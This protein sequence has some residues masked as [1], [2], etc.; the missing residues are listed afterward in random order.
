MK[1]DSINKSFDVIGIKK[2]KLEK[3][4]NQF[5]ESN[6]NLA[7]AILLNEIFEIVRLP[8]VVALLP[9]LVKRFKRK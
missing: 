4:K 2:E 8:A 5:G 9:I 1:I 6:T 7:Y 3:L